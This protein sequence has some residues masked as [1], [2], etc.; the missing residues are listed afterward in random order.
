[1]RAK[2]VLTSAAMLASFGVLSMIFS[3]SAQ[4]KTWSCDGNTCH[5][6][7][8]VVGDTIISYGGVEDHCVSPKMVSP[9]GN[10]SHEARIL[11]KGSS[12]AL[13]DARNSS[14][15]RLPK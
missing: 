3:G 1:M 13:P 6:L 2:L 14:S 15:S 5:S 9:V 11:R 8:C 4:A 7:P 10:G 12:P